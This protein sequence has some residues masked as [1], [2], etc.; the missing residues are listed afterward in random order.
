MNAE[1][2]WR[3]CRFSPLDAET[4]HAVLHDP[5]VLGALVNEDNE[6]WV[7]LVKH[8]GLL[9]HVDSKRS[10]KVMAEEAFR[11]CLE[12]FPSTFLVTRSEHLGD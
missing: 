1:Y 10:P 9:W 7:A 8:D 4:Y 2:E 6:H 5:L 12:T 3:V 11:Q